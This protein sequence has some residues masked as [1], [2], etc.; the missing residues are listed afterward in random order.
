MGVVRSQMERTA[1]VLAFQSDQLAKRKFLVIACCRHRK[2]GVASVQR[3][4]SIILILLS[5]ID[6]DETI[7]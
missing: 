5:A 6:Y 1:W 3:S 7:G 2:D 4:A